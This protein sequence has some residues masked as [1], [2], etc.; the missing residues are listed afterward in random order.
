MTKVEAV[1]VFRTLFS[2]LLATKG[3]N[4]DQPAIDQAWNDWTDSLCKDNSITA[5]QYESWTHPFNK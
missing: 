4:R 5:K 1:K 2:N 3:K